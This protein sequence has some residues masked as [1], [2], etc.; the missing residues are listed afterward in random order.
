[1][2]PEY[3]TRQINSSFLEL[4]LRQFGCLIYAPSQKSQYDLV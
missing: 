1:M 4:L 3:V 2:D